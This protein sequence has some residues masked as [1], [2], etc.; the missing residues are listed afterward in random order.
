M[1]KIILVALMIVL[2]VP[3]FAFLYDMKMLPRE[4]IRKLTDGELEE[5]Y[6]QAKIEE[7]ASHEFHIAAGFSSSKDYDKRKELLRYLFELRREISHRENI[8]IDDLDKNLK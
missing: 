3:A 5:A 6:I 7:E 4:E 2:T 1:K 8:K